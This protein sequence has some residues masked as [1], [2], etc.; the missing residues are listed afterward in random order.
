MSDTWLPSLTTATPQEGFDLAI[1][2]SRMAVKITQPSDDVRARLR[3]DYEGNAT[4][5]IAVSQVVAI[6]FQSVGA[7]NSYWLAS[8]KTPS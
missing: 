2:L 3:T 7:A 8:E 4:D 1:K 5:L 6:H